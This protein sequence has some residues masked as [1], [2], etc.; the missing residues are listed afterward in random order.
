MAHTIKD[1]FEKKFVATDNTEITLRFD[2]P[3]ENG[4]GTVGAY[5]Y[6]PAK[7]KEKEIARIRYSISYP[8]ADKQNKGIICLH[9]LRTKIPRLHGTTE[10]FLEF[11]RSHPKPR[12]EKEILKATQFRKVTTLIVQEIEK[13][14]KKSGIRSVGVKIGT[15]YWDKKLNYKYMGLPD[16]RKERI[17]RS[18]QN[19]LPE[20]SGAREEQVQKI[21]NITH[22]KP[23]HDPKNRFPLTKQNKWRRIK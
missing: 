7:R 9:T 21:A 13:L 8:E 18:Y 15:R 22:I 2:P 10:T 3:D 4:T 23:L 6:N 5:H 19:V 14:A 11:A 12:F 16:A 1:A 17:L 20:I